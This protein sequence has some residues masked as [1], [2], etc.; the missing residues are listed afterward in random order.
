M[1]EKKTVEALARQFQDQIGEYFVVV[2]LLQQFGQDFK[3]Q[4]Q[5]C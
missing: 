5:R 3:V 2:V 1:G 4:L